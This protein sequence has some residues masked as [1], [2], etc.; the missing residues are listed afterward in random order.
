MF[1]VSVCL[2]FNVNEYGEVICHGAVDDARK[3]E[4]REIGPYMV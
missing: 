4:W 2:L 1:L 3:G